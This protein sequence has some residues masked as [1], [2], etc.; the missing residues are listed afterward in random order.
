VY[1]HSYD[2][3][4]FIKEFRRMTGHSPREFCLSVP[5]EIGRQLTLQAGSPRWPASVG[6][7]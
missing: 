4:H 3:A 7:S 6:E 2:R 1:D 5:N